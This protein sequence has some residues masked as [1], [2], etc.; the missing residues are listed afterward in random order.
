LRHGNG[1]HRPPGKGIKHEHDWNWSYTARYDVF[2]QKLNA[3]ARLSA[4][5]GALYGDETLLH[6]LAMNLTNATHPF[7]VCAA[8]AD[9]GKSSQEALVRRLNQEG[10]LRLGIANQDSVVMGVASTLHPLNPATTHG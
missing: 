6:R 7:A 3:D 1:R 8:E 5:R 10:V 9:L 2:Q 4:G